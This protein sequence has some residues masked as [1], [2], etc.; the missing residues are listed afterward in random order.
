MMCN[1]DYVQLKPDNTFWFRE[2]YSH[3]INEL[4]EVIHAIRSMRASAW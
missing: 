1:S 3:R 2:L 4:S